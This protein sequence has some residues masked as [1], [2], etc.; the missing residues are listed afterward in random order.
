MHPEYR[1]SFYVPSFL[2]KYPRLRKRA[3][4]LWAFWYQVTRGRRFVCRRMNYRM[5]FDLDSTHDKYILAFG[6]YEEAQRRRLFSAAREISGSGPPV[7]F[8]DIG[9][10]TG[11]Y[12]LWAHGSGL[13]DRII[14]IEAD[15]RNVAQL[16]ANLFLNDLIGEIDVLQTAAS[17][18]TGEVSFGMAHRKSRDVSR[19]PQDGAIPRG[20]LQR[21]RSTRIDDIEHTRGGAIVAKIDVEGYEGEVIRGMEALLE[22]NRCLLQIEVFPATFDQFASVMAGL[23]FHCFA[24]I[25]NDRYFRNY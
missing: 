9:A 7:V 1:M 6:N 14:A 21:I 18:T 13:F 12:S 15:P 20:T 5:L 3:R 2:M 23:G 16:Q 11:V 17:G 25:G 4:D 19:V 24:E 10:H 8:L 22:G